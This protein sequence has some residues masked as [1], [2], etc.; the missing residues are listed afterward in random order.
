MRCWGTEGLCL[1]CLGYQRA[2]HVWI[3]DPITHP[4]VQE[5]L[6][7]FTNNIRV[8][9]SCLGKFTTWHCF[10]RA[11]SQCWFM[12]V[13]EKWL[14]KA[15]KWWGGWSKNEWSGTIIHYL[16]DKYAAWRY[17]FSW[18][19]WQL[20]C[21]VHGEDDETSEEDLNQCTL[22][23]QLQALE[24]STKALDWKI[25]SS[26]LVLNQKISA[27]RKEQEEESQ[28]LIH[29]LGGLIVEELGKAITNLLGSLLHVPQAQP[30]HVPQLLT[31]IINVALVA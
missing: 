6:D 2:W 16:L 28:H 26:T 17:A 27:S 11:G 9:G 29:S 18:Q 25:E 31:P 30:L 4:P 1:P 12:F 23:L 20:L 3:R 21:I 7:I 5:L 15:V 10:C 19:R 8:L 14:L 22:T 24:S 13:K